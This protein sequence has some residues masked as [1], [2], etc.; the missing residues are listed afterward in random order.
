MAPVPQ[1]EKSD[2]GR[3]K[4]RNDKRTICAG[5]KYKQLE[6]FRKLNSLTANS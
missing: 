5:A 2:I 4:P 3:A 6:I 1:S